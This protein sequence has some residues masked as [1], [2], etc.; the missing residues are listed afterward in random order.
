MITR[1]A[2]EKREVEVLG[3]GA[4]R[5]AGRAAKADVVMTTSGLK[6]VTRYDPTEIVMSARAGTPVYEI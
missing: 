3:Y 2:R 5:N 6:G 1:L 4:L